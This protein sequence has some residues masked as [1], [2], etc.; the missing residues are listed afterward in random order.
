MKYRYDAPLSRITPWIHRPERERER[1]DVW[2]V[3]AWTRDPSTLME[4][5]AQN[6]DSSLLIEPSFQVFLSLLHSSVSLVFLRR[7]RSGTARIR[8]FGIATL[9]RI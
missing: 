4:P 1:G 8:D 2:S 3:I 6:D 7:D 9:L 5:D